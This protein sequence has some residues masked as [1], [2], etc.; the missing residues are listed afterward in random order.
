[1]PPDRFL[2]D[3]CLFFQWTRRVFFIQTGGVSPYC[4]FIKFK[5]S[6]PVQ[7]MIQ[8]RKQRKCTK[9]HKVV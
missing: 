7:I 5:G 8:R 2:H 1:V 3:D 4:N 9:L 6:P